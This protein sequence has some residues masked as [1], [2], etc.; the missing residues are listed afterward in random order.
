[1]HMAC[2]SENGT[3][4]G[5]NG[6]L[7]KQHH[8]LRHPEAAAAHGHLCGPQSTWAGQAL[9][10]G[11]QEGTVAQGPLSPWGERMAGCP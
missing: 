11:G 10:S 9:I 7:V 4:P 2:I 5:G 3:V 6:V 1:M 8:W